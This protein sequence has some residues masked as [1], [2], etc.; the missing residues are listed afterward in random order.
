V[1]RKRVAQNVLR[2][3]ANVADAETITI[4]RDVFELDTNSTSTAGRIVVD[5]T[6]KVTPTLAGPLIVAAINTY[7]TQRLVAVELA[8]GIIGVYGADPVTGVGALACTE[9]L[10]GSGNAWDAVAMV[11]GNPE[12]AVQTVVVQ[13]GAVAAKVAEGNAYF[14]LPF[15]VVAALCGVRTSAGVAKA[16]DG[17]TTVTGN[18]VKMDNAGSS[19]WAA[20]DVLV[21]VASG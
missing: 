10:A 3:A 15:T 7:N 11:G 2:L 16:W 5:V 4:G 13:R 20:T 19:D 12:V 8:T 18:R 1:G 6:G 9:T 21:C 14:F 17:A